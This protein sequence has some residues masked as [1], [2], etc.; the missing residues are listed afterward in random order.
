MS[1]VNSPVD[2]SRIVLRGIVAVVLP[3]ITKKNEKKK[4]K[5]DTVDPPRFF[6]PSQSSVMLFLSTYYGQ[7]VHRPA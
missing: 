1:L 5:L 2:F 7:K 3:W 4:R 6:F